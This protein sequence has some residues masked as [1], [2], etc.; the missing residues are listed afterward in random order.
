MKLRAERWGKAAAILKECPMFTD[1][2]LTHPFVLPCKQWAD[3]ASLCDCPKLRAGPHLNA[4]RGHPATFKDVSE[5]AMRELLRSPFWFARKFDRGAVGPL[6]QRE[7]ERL[8]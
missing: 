7:V 6:A 4:N 5:G 1:W 8:F 2:T 3:H